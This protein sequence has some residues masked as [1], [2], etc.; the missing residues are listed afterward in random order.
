MLNGI[1]ILA[2]DHNIYGRFAYN[3]LLTIR[4]VEPDAKIALAYD[5]AGVSYLLPEQLG[6]FDY[7]IPVTGNGFGGKL[8]LDLIS[9]FDRTIALDADM[10]WLP[11]HP[12]STL[13]ANLEGVDFT[14]ITEGKID[15]ETGADESNGHYFWWADIA[16]I[17]QVYKLD[18][19][20]LYQWRSEMM[21]FTKSAQV[22]KMFA[23]ARK[24]HAQPRLKSLKRFGL[25]VPD[26]LAL[27]IATAQSD[28]HP[29]KYK[30]TP[31]YWPKLHGEHIVSLADM[32][33]RY[34]LFSAGSHTASNT[35]KR[36]YEST[37]AAAA[38][39]LGERN[40]F[41]LQNK[42]HAI[43]DRLKF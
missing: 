6:R 23:K 21:Y 1:L 5:D 25:Q 13:F 42:A 16:E 32:H 2:T 19:G 14:A 37:V 20:T 17:K 9:P 4:A 39:K 33:E 24:I 41:P 3:L 35:T 31:S 38:N 34:Y 12:P 22:K 15:L 40:W 18:K 10:V 28:T 8:A 27:N 26:E 7:L 36:V 29:H 30:W 43:P 11:K